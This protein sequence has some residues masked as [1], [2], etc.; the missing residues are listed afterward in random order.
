MVTG[1]S[2]AMGTIVAA[3]FVVAAIEDAKSSRVRIRLSQLITLVA[4]VGFALISL[5][6]SSWDRL[7]SA[8]L[9][10]AIVGGVQ[11]IP[12]WWQARGRSTGGATDRIGKADVRLAVPFGWTLGWY[13]VGYA[14]VG[15]AVALGLG[16]LFSLATRRA[17]VPF[18]PFLAVGLTLGVGLGV[19]ALVESGVS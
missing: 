7:L 3:L 16:V 10:V 6:A 13:G 5:V 19:A 9:G 12:Y 4:I 15:F 8:L 11:A 17:S 18:I 14:V 2:I 1:A